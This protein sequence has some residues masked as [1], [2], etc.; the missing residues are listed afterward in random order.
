MEEMQAVIQTQDI[1]VLATVSGSSPHCSLMAYVPDEKHRKL[2]MVTHRS[3]KKFANLLENPAVSLLIDT[4]L[5]DR[6]ISRED[7]WALTLNGVFEQ[8]ENSE[9]VESI[10][11]SFVKKHKHLHEF[12]HH[13]DA[14]V[15]AIKLQSLQL[16][17]SATDA[18]YLDYG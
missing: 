16:L 5:S 18:D 2:F 8:I 12:A 7:V 9:D 4:R 6:P 3:T 17:R 13:P 14:V 1:C 11:S 10:R 15:F